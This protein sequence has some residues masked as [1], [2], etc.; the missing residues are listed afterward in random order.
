M[1]D[2]LSS[3]ER[4]RIGIARAFLHDSLLI[5]LDE[6]TS[7]LDSFNEALI[8]RSLKTQCYSKTVVMVSHRN[9]TMKIA[10]TIYNINS[11]RLS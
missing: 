8:L 6:P 4:Q 1:G 7:N 10:D 5:L 2:K 11:G 3:G 9:S